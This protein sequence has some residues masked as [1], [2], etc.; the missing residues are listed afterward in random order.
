MVKL[1]G[2]SNDFSRVMTGLWSF[3]NV[4]FPYRTKENFHPGM[5]LRVMMEIFGYEGVGKSTLTAYLAARVPQPDGV[6]QIADL[7][8]A[9]E[10]EHLKSN[11]TNAGFDG[12][13]HL[14]DMVDKKG[15]PRTHEEV[16]QEAAG[17]LLEKRTN[18]I[19][20][21]SI[22]AVQAVAEATNDLGEA[23][24][25]R[26]AKLIGD[27]SRR[28]VANLRLAERS[29]LVLAINHTHG[30]IGGRGHT[31]NGG[32]TLKMLCG[33]RLNITRKEV[34]DD[35]STIIQAKPEKLRFGGLAP[36][37]LGFAVITPGFGINP[38][39][40]LVADCVNLRLAERKS[41][42]KVM[43]EKG[44]LRSAGRL[45]TLIERSV[46]RDEETFA[47][48]RKALELYGTTRPISSDPSEGDHPEDGD[49]DTGSSD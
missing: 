9:A 32:V 21:D 16:L 12:E 45:S 23:N 10:W 18:A 30:V 34:F 28:I 48:F 46:Q 26:H 5:P 36:D 20:I 35:G 11:V 42:V 40:S 39:L 1:T 22:G 29:K 41:V 37:R 4:L 33:Y 47:P 15:K 7:E 31:T 14:I 38:Y 3:D 49:E 6:I 43:D 24:M 2:Q 8:T 27:W 19:I 25:G 44:D 17:S 13:V